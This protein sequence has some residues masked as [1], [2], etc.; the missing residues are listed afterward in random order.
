[1]EAIESVLDQSFR[2]FE[3]I[4]V[5]DG[6]TDGTEAAVAQF[7]DHIRY[8]RRE[9]RGVAAAR[10]VGL[11]LARGH[12]LA[13]I[14]SDNLWLRDHL[15]VVVAAL[16]ARPQALLAST[17]EGFI[18]AGR[19]NAGDA[20]VS[21]PLPRLLAANFVGSPSCVATRRRALEA[22]GGFDEEL[23]VAE[24][25]DAWLRLAVRGPF[26][27]V[28]RRTAVLRQAADSL[29]LR[30][31]R[32]GLYLEA[33]ERIAARMPAELRAARRHH[34][35]DRARGSV[36]FAAALR[37]LAEHDDPALRRELG[38]A[39][40]LFPELSGEPGLVSGRLRVNLPGSNVPFERLRHLA[41]AA[42]AWPE[43]AS[44]TA[45]VLRLSAAGAALRLGR[46]ATAVRLVA[47]LPPGAALS[48]G[49]R[50]LP[51]ARSALARRRSR[52]RIR[53]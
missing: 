12:V 47:G 52:R 5:D 19:M 22:I 35:V 6:S 4:V 10:N 33:W 44:D 16:R 21:D 30:G 18:T 38:A 13:F 48:L 2:S 3:L 17:C 51:L 36:H 7:D 50:A 15:D 27:F 37:A 49:R 45:T 29:L 46:A 11:H 25:A 53:A 34:L 1:M 41:T 43:P 8:E 23:E 42:V 39:C 9:H 24:D 14:D 40:R 26:A 31:R 20:V 32:E 28:R